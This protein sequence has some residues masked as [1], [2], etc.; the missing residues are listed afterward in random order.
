MLI[1]LCV[2]IFYML[3]LAV[4]SN[5][6]LLIHVI[7]TK[8]R[9]EFSSNCNTVYQIMEISRSCHGIISWSDLVIYKRLKILLLVNKFH[10]CVS[11][12]N[13]I[14]PLCNLFHQRRHLESHVPESRCSH[15]TF[16]YRTCFEQGVPWH[17]S[18]YREFLLNFSS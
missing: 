17:S 2:S 18:N 15:L 5:A 7:I 11:L 10:C 12:R 6:A 14:L 9:T 13:E 3:T 8:T 4:S 16:K 1:I